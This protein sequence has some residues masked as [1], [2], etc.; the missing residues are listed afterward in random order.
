MT[1]QTPNPGTEDDPVWRPRVTVATIVPSDGRYLL[2]EEDIRGRL[3]LNQP[4]G[5]LEPGESLVD[6]ARR[7]TREETGWDV[8][9]DCL[10]SIHQWVNPE[11]DRHFLRF[12]FAARALRH[13]PRQPLDAGI[14]AAVW[15][16]RS[17]IA[18]ATPRLRSPLILASID[19]WLG[20]TRLPLSSLHYLAPGLERA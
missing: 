9:P 12:T 3:L 2:V 7:E 10:V 6:A 4:A 17:E 18:D 5:H 1:P 11:L 13:D 20:G 14:R 15:M 16:S 19:A 8:E